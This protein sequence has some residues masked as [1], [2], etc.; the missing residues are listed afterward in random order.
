MAARRRVTARRG[1]STIPSN[2]SPAAG[3]ALLF[4]L[5]GYVVTSAAY[6]LWTRN[7][8][9]FSTPG[10]ILAA[11]AAPVMYWLARAKGRIAD[12]I[13]S[14]ALRAD[15]AE[16]IACAYLSITVLIGLLVQAATG[17]WWVDSVTA[18]AIVGF[19][20]KEGFEAWR[21]D[22]PLT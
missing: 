13:N 22:D 10:L 7:G 19:L 16:S 3:G 17:A 20:V 5:A 12:Q 15:A 8:Q 6:G 1:S 21:G 18:L 14:A 9:E 2:G 4:A 11:I